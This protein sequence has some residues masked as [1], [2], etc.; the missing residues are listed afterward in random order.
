MHCAAPWLGVLNLVTAAARC[1]QRG[2]AGGRAA[3]LSAAAALVEAVHH[4]LGQ[5]RSA[6]LPMAPSQVGWCRLTLSEPV[7]KA[8]LVSALETRIS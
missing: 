3:T 2:D 7:L 5:P 4:T 8:P 1:G 6:H